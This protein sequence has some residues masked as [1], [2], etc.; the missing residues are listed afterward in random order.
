VTLLKEELPSDS[1]SAQY[2]DA[3][4]T[5]TRRTEGYI[6]SILLGMRPERQFSPEEFALEAVLNAALD[7]WNADAPPGRVVEVVRAI[8]PAAVFGD[9]KL[10][11]SAVT[12]LLANARFALAT[13]GKLEVELRRQTIPGTETE[14]LGL[15]TDD[16]YSLVVRD[17][18]FGMP[19]NVAARAFE[20]FFTT[21]T[22]IKAAGLGLT[23]VHSVV[24][25]HGGQVE[26]RS[27]EEQGTAVTVW[28]PAGAGLQ[29][30]FASQGQNASRG[31]EM[32][33]QVLLIEDDPLMKEVL[34][35]WLGRIDLDVHTAAGAEEAWSVFQ[36]KQNE[37][38][39]VI[40]ET[41]FKGGTGEEVYALFGQLNR[42]V[43]WIFLAGKRR[44]AIPVGGED[45]RVGPL[46]M[47]K[48]VTLRALAEVVRRHAAG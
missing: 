39:L 42:T 34:R 14:R 48:P 40:T 31:S 5:A 2:L 9:E 15:G 28:I 13:G 30:R 29:Q 17:H 16:V 36:R 35:D 8:E 11:K 24:Q 23:I 21:R 4:D 38:A 27:Q 20:P 45:G 3:M 37:L 25:I 33:K 46:V 10:W 12:Q 7:H 44:P 32:R 6:E 22:Q 1:G 18:G 19:A 26:L 43:P 47:Q 41:D